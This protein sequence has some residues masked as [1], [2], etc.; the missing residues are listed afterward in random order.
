MLYNAKAKHCNA[1]HYKYIT[2]ALRPRSQAQ[3]STDL[4]YTGTVLR[5]QP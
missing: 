5:F 3:I 4:I 1:L 2:K